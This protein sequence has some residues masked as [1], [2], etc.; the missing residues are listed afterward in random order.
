MEK[1]GAVIKKMPWWPF[2]VGGLALL[3]FGILA[4]AWPD[5]T[6]AVLVAVFGAIALVDG[7]FTTAGGLASHENKTLR[8]YLVAAGLFSIIIGLLI[9]VWPDITAK[10]VLYIIATFAVVAGATRALTA[11]FWPEERRSDRIVL[12][13]LGVLG[14]AFGI[15]IF[16]WPAA[17]AL[18]IVWLIGLWA[19]VFGVAAMIVG[20]QIRTANQR[21]AKVA[22][23]SQAAP[24][25]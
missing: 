13:V 24:K 7:V 20:F 19:I 11:A 9:L 17:G 25:R 14:L 23:S 18:A 3:I 15:V 6:V 1:A 16:V 12:I 21:L 2:V 8:W 4:I 10:V 22:E 5:I